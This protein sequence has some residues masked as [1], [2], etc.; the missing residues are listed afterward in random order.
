MS[1]GN[2]SCVKKEEPPGSG[3]QTEFTIVVTLE[4]QAKAPY[5]RKVRFPLARNI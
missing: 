3:S 5:G 1:H 4:G 2:V